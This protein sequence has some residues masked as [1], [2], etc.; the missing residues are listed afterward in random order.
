M[1]LHPSDEQELLTVMK[2]SK[3]KSSAGYDGIDMC[4]VKR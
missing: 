4:V 2:Q 3:G 1:F